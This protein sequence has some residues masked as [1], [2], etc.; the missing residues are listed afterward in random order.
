[1][2]LLPDSLLHYQLNR[3]PVQ[4]K[5]FQILTQ[6]VTVVVSVARRIMLDARQQKLPRHVAW[7]DSAKQVW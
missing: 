3:L 1:M 4:P 5:L 6:P 7:G 2:Q